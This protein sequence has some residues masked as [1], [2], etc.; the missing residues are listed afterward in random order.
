MASRN[1]INDYR[2]VCGWTGKILLTLLFVAFSGQLILAMDAQIGLRGRWLRHIHRIRSGKSFL[3]PLLE[4]LL[5]PAL[6][7]VLGLFVLRT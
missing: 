4:S 7:V 2:P 3:Q 6:F 5:E 1:M